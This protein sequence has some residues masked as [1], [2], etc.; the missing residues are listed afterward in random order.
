MLTPDY[1]AY[2]RDKSISITEPVN[3]FILRDV[4]RRVAEAGQFT[5]TAAYQAYI[6][7]M[8]G[9]KD[10]EKKLAL[11]LNK[12]EEET[13]RL[14]QGAA[15]FGYNADVKRFPDALAFEE[16]ASI[17]NI[18]NGA[19]WLTG[20]GMKNI[21]KT[22]GMT[23]P[24]GGALPLREA[25]VACT[26]YAFDNVITGA[27]DYNTAIRRAVERIA[28]KGV[29]A[30]DYQ[31]GMRTS[32][33]AAVRRNIM[34]GLGLMEEQISKQNHDDL[35]AD[36]WEIS[37]H[38]N[39]APDHEPIQGRQ[40]SDKEY[41][42]LNNSLV[43]RISTLNCGHIASPIIMGVSSPQY[44]EK[45]LQDMRGKNE[46]GV[47]IDGKH[48][49][50]YETTQVQRQLETAMRYQKRRVSLGLNDKTKLRVLQQ[51]YRRFSKAAGLRTQYER[52]W[53]AK[54]A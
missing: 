26:D 13:A 39:S 28:Q 42:E 43:R 6:S 17:Q 34:G 49:T 24:Y 35:G 8:L 27:M 20:G 46:A 19:L 12:T 47:T 51:E 40:Y 52:A 25:Y 41:E 18:V 5:S 29:L 15:E 48:Y 36:G 4:A 22:L 30:V 44:S 37:A 3:D 11:L 32:V 10:F 54:G 7:K 38:A 2:L 16:N 9:D 50:G 45:E 14:I 33:E 1:L 21:T 31:S 23:G 53:I